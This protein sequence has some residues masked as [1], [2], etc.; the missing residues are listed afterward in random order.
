MVKFQGVDYFDIESLLS[1]EET[2]VRDT[3]REFTDDHILPIIEKHN[4][5]GSFPIELIPKMA[6]L[7]MF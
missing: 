7:G 5:A 4:R 6:D 1:E 2:L 3:V